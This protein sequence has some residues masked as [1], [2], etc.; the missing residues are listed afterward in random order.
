V[1]RQTIRYFGV[2]EEYKDAV[3]EAAEEHGVAAVCSN[4]TVML[5]GTVS[6]VK[7]VIY[8]KIELSDEE[9]F[10]GKENRMQPIRTILDS[11]VSVEAELESDSET[12]NRYDCLLEELEPS[13]DDL[14]EAAMVA[15]GGRS[16]N[17]TY[18]SIIEQNDSDEK[19]NQGPF[20][21]GFID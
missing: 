13:S 2:D 16:E 9:K 10:D 14:Q 3:F 1:K 19:I 7:D 17:S 8:D 15:D 21:R 4:D 5:K 12:E 11:S 20:G 6:D 18:N